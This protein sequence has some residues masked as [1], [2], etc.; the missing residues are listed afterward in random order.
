LLFPDWQGIVHFKSFIRESR[1]ER[2]IEKEI[3]IAFYF[4]TQTL[5]IIII[6]VFLN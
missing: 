2:E 3:A 5:E 1:R 4:D 6:A